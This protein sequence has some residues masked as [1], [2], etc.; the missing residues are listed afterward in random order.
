MGLARSPAFTGRLVL[1]MLPV[2][3]PSL[4]FGLLSNMRVSLRLEPVAGFEPVTLRLEGG[5][6]AN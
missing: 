1:L 6:S 3:I 4:R 2:I 5:C